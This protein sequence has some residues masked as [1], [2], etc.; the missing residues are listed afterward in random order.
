MDKLEHYLDQV[1]R[2]IGGPRSLR[3]HI[4]QELGEHLR[5]AVDEHRAA[6]LSEEEALARAL[7]D[8]GGPE[9]VRSE[10]EAT[11]GQRLMAVAIDKAMQWK[12]MTMKAKYLWATW[13][14]LAL[15]G[16]VLGEIATILFAAV[17]LAPKLEHFLRDTQFSLS[18]PMG[19]SWIPSFLR[20]LE[21]IAH[22][23]MWCVLIFVIAWVLF[24]WRIHSENK[25]FIRLSALATT[26]FGLM[27]M[28]ALTGGAL[29]L[30]SMLLVAT[31]ETRDP[32]SVVIAQTALVDESVSALEKAL[33]NKDWNQCGWTAHAAS[34]AVDTLTRTGGAASALASLDEQS[35]VHELRAKLESA[36]K[37]LRVAED[38][39]LEKNA[40]RLEDALQKFHKSFDPLRE[41]AIKGTR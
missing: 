16:V 5:D 8:F 1:C 23:G 37:S 40:A 25:S 41:R 22:Y 13:A 21:W 27:V 2:T 20:V 14:H 7:E 24:E 15:T 3:Q 33:A 10:L 4:R 34:H 30:P 31:M 28:V 12:E 19:V 26:A 6:G 17:F 18:N 9:Q 38:A 39:A 11:H 35:K 32:E 36:N 29:V